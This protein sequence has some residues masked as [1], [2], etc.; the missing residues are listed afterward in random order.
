M[1]GFLFQGVRLWRLSKNHSP[2]ARDFAV[3]GLAG[4]VGFV[5]LAQFGDVRFFAFLN[6]LLFAIYGFVFAWTHDIQN[7]SRVLPNVGSE[8]PSNRAIVTGFRNGPRSASRVSA[9]KCNAPSK[10]VKFGRPSV[11]SVVDKGRCGPLLMQPCDIESHRPDRVGDAACPKW[12]RF[13]PFR[14][15][16]KYRYDAVTHN[17]EG[18]DSVMVR[19]NHLFEACTV[20]D[21]RRR[22]CSSSIRAA[23]SSPTAHSWQ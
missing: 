13:P 9:P 18:S 4:L 17:R 22:P 10:S 14:S 15:G 21:R 5:F 11:G 2:P 12:L 16:R 20:V 3:A 19:A 6:S 8:P 23:I 1:A 7:T